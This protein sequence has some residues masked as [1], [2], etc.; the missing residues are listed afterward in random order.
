MKIRVMMMMNKKIFLKE[1]KTN[2][3]INYIRGFLINGLWALNAK[4][5]NE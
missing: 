3:K 4:I 5:K 2:K 1:T